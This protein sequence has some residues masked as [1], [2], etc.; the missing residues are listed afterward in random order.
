[1]RNDRHIGRL[2]IVLGYFIVGAGYSFQTGEAFRIVTRYNFTS[3]AYLF[4]YISI[5]LVFIISG[6]SWSSLSRVR[7]ENE[8]ARRYWRRALKGLSLQSL[9]LAVASYFLAQVELA[10]PFR[11][12]NIGVGQFIA[13]AG[14]LIL[15]FGFWNVAS[16]KLVEPTAV[17]R[18]LDDGD[19][20]HRGAS[21]IVV[22]YVL[23]ATGCAV[24]AVSTLVGN[25]GAISVDHF[26]SR[27]IR[28]YCLPGRSSHWLPNCG[29]FMVDSAESRGR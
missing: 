4:Y 29:G 3:V 27:A 28:S 6:W 10:L 19:T 25:A 20:S 14:G 18:E 8:T 12:T 2:L 11:G 17:A 24:Q 16:S 5:P 1:M 13:S 26:S 23:M 7:P 9:V 22:G 21:L 15:A